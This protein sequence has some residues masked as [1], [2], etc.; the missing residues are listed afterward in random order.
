L[1]T[2][3]DSSS[4]ISTAKDTETDVP[5][6]ISEAHGVVS[7]GQ[8]DGVISYR[9]KDG[10]SVSSTRMPESSGSSNSQQQGDVQVAM[11]GADLQSPSCTRPSFT[12]G[13]QRAASLRQRGKSSAMPPPKSR[14]HGRHRS[15]VAPV[16][17]QSSQ[18]QMDLPNS[19]PTVN[20]QIPRPKI[21][22]SRT[23]QTRTANT[24][25]PASHPVSATRAP[26]QVAV[27]VEN[28]TKTK[29]STRVE[30][31]VPTFLER[32]VKDKDQQI[33]QHTASHVRPRTTEGPKRSS[34]LM[35]PETRK[36]SKPQFSTYQQHFSPRK[37]SSIRTGIIQP[38]KSDGKD[39]DTPHPVF[40]PLQ[41]E[42]LYLHILH[43]ASC[44]TRREWEQDAK[45]RLEYRFDNVTATY[46]S[47]LEAE[48][49]ARLALNDG[50]IEAWCDGGSV[51]SLE[52][53]VRTL[54]RTIQ[55]L[56]ELSHPKGQYTAIITQFVNS[57]W[58]VRG[59]IAGNRVNTEHALLDTESL[60]RKWA[61]EV[62]VVGRKV[63]RCLRTLD[64]LGDAS[65]SSNLGEIL[66]CHR[67]LA[68]N[69]LQEMKIM[70]AIEHEEVRIETLRRKEEILGVLAEEDGDGEPRKE[71][72]TAWR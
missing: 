62:A 25:Q 43:E 40:G 56:W 41:T 15:T 64:S 26:P 22:S 5:Q 4:L 65:S 46:H 51:H 57:F 50:S 37:P 17:D 1:A 39:R 24:F 20:P 70:T 29:S 28:S 32:E 47:V 9:N 19:S 67:D 8:L 10:S 66:T 49:N 52:N 11:N 31:L 18:D 7:Y 42:L 6:D 27:L 21:T 34:T 54:G 2:D 59:D 69:M 12:Q 71:G 63:D 23:P 60:G 38:T 48:K 45:T 33:G 44:R 14:S 36:A 35:T 72:R 13:L 53:K 61:D 58:G 55:E 30:Q 68:T 16:V 3:S